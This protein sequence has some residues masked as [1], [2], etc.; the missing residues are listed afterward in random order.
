MF[1]MIE[2]Y[3]SKLHF[4]GHCYF[5]LLNNTLFTFLGYAALLQLQHQLG[6]KS[7]IDAECRDFLSEYFTPESVELPVLSEV[8][9]NPEDIPLEGYNGHI[10]FLL[11][12]EKYRKGKFIHFFPPL[13]TGDEKNRGGYKWVSILSFKSSSTSVSTQD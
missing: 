2:F 12:D 9:C 11:T 6:V 8:F 13:N 10:K 7:Y 4:R 1:A 3:N 5:N